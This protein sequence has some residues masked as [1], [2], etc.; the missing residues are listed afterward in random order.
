[1]GQECGSRLHMI[2]SWRLNYGASTIPYVG[3]NG[4]PKCGAL[5][6]FSSSGPIQAIIA[7]LID[8]NPQKLE[9]SKHTIRWLFFATLFHLYHLL[10]HL[11]LKIDLMVCGIH[12]NTL[13]LQGIVFA[14][15]HSF[16]GYSLMC[17][18]HYFMG[19]KMA[20]W[21]HGLAGQLP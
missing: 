4:V 18:F 20:A 9:A 2:T 7:C 14:Q 11:P 5:Q 15:F 12:A 8:R 16:F 13:K 1:M 6:I 10:L 21:S 19:N 17:Y 3:A